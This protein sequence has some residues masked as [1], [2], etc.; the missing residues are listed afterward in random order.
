MAQQNETCTPTAALHLDTVSPDPTPHRTP[1]DLSIFSAPALEV[2]FQWWLE[3]NRRWTERNG[4]KALTLP[5]VVRREA[6]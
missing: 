6:Q 4:S 5:P 1:D 3:S 2:V